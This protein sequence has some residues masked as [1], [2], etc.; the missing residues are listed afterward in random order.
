MKVRRKSLHRSRNGKLWKKRANQR[1]AKERKRLAR[2]ASPAPLTVY[3]FTDTHS[4][5]K[6]TGFRVIIECLDDGERVQFTTG[7][8]PHGLT[9]SPTLAGRRVACVLRH[10]LPVNLAKSDKK[11]DKAGR[12]APC[13]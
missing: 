2:A 12:S 11:R 9:I 6:P 7:R 5:P 3:P 13:P 10:Y 8:G 4:Y 1:A